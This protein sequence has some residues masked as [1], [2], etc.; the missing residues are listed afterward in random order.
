MLKLFSLV[1]LLAVL[2]AVAFLAKRQLTAI[3][4][5]AAGGSAAGSATRV[6]QAAQDVRRALEQ[7]A[8]ARASEVGQ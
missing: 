5:A 2:V 8:A 4:P 3:V 6:E 1:G 7:G